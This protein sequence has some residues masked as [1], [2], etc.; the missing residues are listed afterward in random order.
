[1]RM[2]GGRAMLTPV[3]SHESTAVVVVDA[4]GRIQYWSAGA[5]LLFGRDNPT[6]E[7]L[8]VIV[9]E[10]YR[11]MHW[12]GFNRAM[13]TGESRISGDRRNIPVRCGDGEAKAF[14][15]TFS[16]VRDG[17]GRPVGAIAV[18]SSRRGDEEPFSAIADDSVA[19]RS[20]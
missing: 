18:W 17:F 20:E 16:V 11:E 5:T 15:G 7:T 6:G 13:A 1:M 4:T 12:G 19:P 3:E 2:R 8:D 10:E 9:P 14:P